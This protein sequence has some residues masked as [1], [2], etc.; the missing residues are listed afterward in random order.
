MILLVK[1]VQGAVDCTTV[2]NANGTNTDGT[3]TCNSLYSWNTTSGTCDWDCSQISNTNATA[4]GLGNGTC[5]C[6]AFYSWDVVNSSCVW[7]CSL[8]SNTSANNSINA[9]NETCVCS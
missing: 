4:T 7:D 2:T 3:C 1:G 9:E 8:I 5:E 6:V